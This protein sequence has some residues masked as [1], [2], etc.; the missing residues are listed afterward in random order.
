MPTNIN[1]Y[2][3][4]RDSA[5]TMGMVFFG[6]K[7]GRPQARRLK[8]LDVGISICDVITKGPSL[9]ENA[10]T[11]NEDLAVVEAFRAFDHQ[12]K[13]R[14]D[15]LSDL[16]EDAESVKQTLLNLKNGERVPELELDKSAAFF[17]NI[18]SAM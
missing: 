7:Y 6:L 2:D 13:V 11:N 17:R 15:K 14:P 18:Y 16:E 1:T 10:I 8:Y 12:R 9:S 3:E 5:A 4:L